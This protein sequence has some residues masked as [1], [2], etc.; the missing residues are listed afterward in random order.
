[1]SELL[2]E[3][4]VTGESLQALHRELDF[5]T[6]EGQRIVVPAIH[7]K[8]WGDSSFAE[9]HGLRYSYMA[10]SMA[11][12]ISSVALVKAMAIEGFLGSFGAAGLGLHAV[13]RAIDELQRDLGEQTFAVNFIHTPGEP[14]IEER[15]CDLLIQKNVRLVEA[16]AFMRITKALVR[17]RV[18]GLQKAS[19]GR[20]VS[21]RRIIAKVS[22]TELAKL[23][24]APAPLAILDALLSEGVIDSKE[25]AIA[26]TVPLANDLTVEA[27][28]GGHTD[29]RPLVTL[30]PQMLLLKNEMEAAYRYQEPLRVGAAGGIATPHAALAALSMGASYLVTGTVNQA[31]QEAG[32]SDDVR[33]MLAETQQSDLIMAPAADMFEMGVKLQVLKRGTMFPMRAQK[34]YELYRAYPDIDS[35]PDKDRKILEDTY[36]R[37]SLETA[38]Q[39]TKRFFAER[40]PTQITLA[41]KNPKHKMALVFRS[42]LGQ[43]SHWANRGQSD[44]KIDYQVWCGPA[45]AAFNDWARGSV[46]ETVSERKA[47]YVGLNL[48]YGSAILHRIRSLQFQGLKR[49]EWE[50]LAKPM[51]EAKLRSLLENGR[52]G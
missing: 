52:H 32:T 3:S 41:E 31:C 6:V 2:T 45:M 38:W 8:N 23:F 1:M 35:L 20:I 15:L 30:L 4:S 25:H 29:N 26:Q 51:A 10:G 27:D 49:P 9:M 50:A 43:S 33:K 28:S 13:A 12:G 21:P 7:M 42:Y 22:R 36:F 48:L 11:H 39:E 34:L 46:L 47:G 14:L 17:Y 37:M 18:K 40:D 44:R 16:S 24:W 5:Y 19:D